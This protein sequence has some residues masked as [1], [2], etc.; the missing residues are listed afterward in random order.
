MRGSVDPLLL[1][2]N[3]AVL[4]NKL[5]T[6]QGSL[7]ARIAEA[8]G[9]EGHDSKSSEEFQL[10]RQQIENEALKDYVSQRMLR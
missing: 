4:R 2:G 8:E 7:R 6:G 3:V 10:K 5:Q 9:S 1:R